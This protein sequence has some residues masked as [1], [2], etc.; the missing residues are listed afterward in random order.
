VGHE[1]RLER[2]DRPALGERLADLL[3]LA[4]ELALGLE[5]SFATVRSAAGTASSGPPRR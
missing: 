4:V 3:G 5:P 1:R 2:D